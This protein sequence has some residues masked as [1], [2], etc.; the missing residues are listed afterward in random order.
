MLDCIVNVVLA[1]T[2]NMSM[3]LGEVNGSGTDGN[4]YI[5]LFGDDGNTA[6]IQLRQSGDTKNRFESG[7]LYKFTV[8]TV[9]IGK[10]ND[11][12]L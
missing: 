5:Q 12:Y 3:R 4:V 11:F 1:A 10:V 6:K 9:D 2:Y 8:G 7:E